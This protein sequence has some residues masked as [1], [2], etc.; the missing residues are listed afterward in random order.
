M[1]FDLLVASSDSASLQFLKSVTEDNCLP[2][3]VF[4]TH[5]IQNV[6]SLIVSQFL[7]VLSPHVLLRQLEEV[8]L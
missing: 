2:L 3:S 5:V 1:R 4:F 6:I 8:Y 7:F